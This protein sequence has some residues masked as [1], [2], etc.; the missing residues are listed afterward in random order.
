MLPSCIYR[1]LIKKI[2]YFC[3]SFIHSFVNQNLFNFNYLSIRKIENRDEPR[4]EVVVTNEHITMRQRKRT[5]E[6]KRKKIIFFVFHYFTSTSKSRTRSFVSSVPLRLP[7]AQTSFV[8]L[9]RILHTTPPLPPL[10][11]ATRFLIKSPVHQRKI[12]L[13]M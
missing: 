5:R 8:S 7:T 11:S 1:I 4:H 9:A 6:R 3:S 10:S 12:Q 2:D 13:T